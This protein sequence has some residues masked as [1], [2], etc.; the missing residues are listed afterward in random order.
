MLWLA[1]TAQ[2]GRLQAAL[3][4]AATTWLLHPLLVVVANAVMALTVLRQGVRESALVFGLGA[5]ALAVLAWPWAGS[6]AIGIAASLTMVHWLPT[7]VLAGVL[8]VTTS[9]PLA[10]LTAG[11]MAVLAMGVVALLVDDLSTLWTEMA[12]SML[13]YLEQFGVRMDTAAQVA[14]VQENAV[15]MTAMSAASQMVLIV[16]SLFIGRAWQAGLDRPGAFAEEFRRLRLGI[17]PAVAVVVLSAI[18]VLGDSGLAAGLAVIG[19]TLFVFQG[20]AVVHGV[21]HQRKL[22][23]GW[24]VGM[25]LSLILP[26]MVVICALLGVV[27]SWVDVRGRLAA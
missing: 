2:R 8:R 21:V 11:F 17:A 7:M 18:A 1:R 16:L 4:A 13:P 27:D 20:L 23:R 12:Q 25:Y 19:A 26:Q 5:V 15:L 10:L 24:L 14:W 9:M 6:A 3:V 22:G